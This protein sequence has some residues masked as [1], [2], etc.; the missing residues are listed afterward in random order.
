MIRIA[1]AALFLAL[2]VFLFFSEILGL[3]KF[4]YVMDR[5]HA[6][7]LGDTLGIVFVVLGVAVLGGVSVSVIKLLLIPA[8]M[9]LTGP[10]I[11]HLIAQAEVLCRRNQG[12]EY[13]EE[14]R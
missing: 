10:V 12:S 3:F 13:E 1:A 9:F 11:T 8:F 14:Y 4:R 6:A 5:I 2:A 7:A